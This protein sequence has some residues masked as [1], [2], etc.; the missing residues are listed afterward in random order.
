MPRARNGTAGAG[1]LRRMP[2]RT[3]RIQLEGDY[4][5]FS[6][7]MRSNP[8]LRVFTGIQ[9]NQDFATLR[10]IM[11]ELIIDWDFV[12]ENGA[13]LPVGDLEAVSIDLFGMIVTRYLA[14]VAD[15]AQV[16]KA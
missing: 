1:Q 5:D 3:Q 12:D 7:V 6:L 9:A 14:T 16:P 2:V 13:V 15:T 4:A 10:D 11:H 8:P